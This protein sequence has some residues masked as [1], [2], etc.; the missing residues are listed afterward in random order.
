MKVRSLL[1][2]ILVA[3]LLGPLVLA[4]IWLGGYFTLAFVIIV[5]GVCV[6]EFHRMASKKGAFGDL[7]ISELIAI[8]VCLAFYFNPNF[9]ISFTIIGTMVVLFTELYRPK[10]SSLL[11]TSLT[12]F[13]G[14]YFSLL[15]GCFILI[16]Q[17]PVKV[18]VAYIEAG[19]W[20]IMLIFATWVCDTAAYFFGSFFG[21]KKLMQRI[22]PNKTI[23]GAIAGFIFGVLTAYV[24]HLWFIDELAVIDSLMIGAI[25]GSFGQYGDLFESMFKRD[26]DVKDASNILPG[27]G[28]LMD[29]FDSLM[30]SAPVIFLYLRYI[31]FG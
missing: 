26:V 17:L 21:K 9:I 11:N 24:C 29:R 12:L 18:G 1:S 30:I 31:V 20:L 19:Q 8:A 13:S 15:F 28:G 6:W 22:S 16:R 25:A 3:V 10:G 4:L 2:R 7:L 5:V 14:L 27:H 23:V